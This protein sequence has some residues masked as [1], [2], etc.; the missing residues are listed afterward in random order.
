[1]RF[2]ACIS[3]L[4]LSLAP[5]GFAQQSGKTSGLTA[6]VTQLPSCAVCLGTMAFQTLADFSPAV[7][8]Y[9]GHRGLSMRT[10]RHS[11]YLHRRKIKCQR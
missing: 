6:I 7:M 8:S 1:M 2:M 9:T 4:L 11:M 3:L 10:D 5:L